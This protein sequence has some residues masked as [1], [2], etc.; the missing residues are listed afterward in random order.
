MAGGFA[1]RPQLT[2]LSPRPKSM[3]VAQ[4]SKCSTSSTLFVLAFEPDGL[5]SLLAPRDVDPPGTATHGAV[6]L[7]ALLFGSAWVDINFC[8]FAAVRAPKLGL[9]V[10]VEVELSHH[11]AGA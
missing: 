2:S 8:R 10:Q 1:P 3:T 9:R 6:L 4:S 11:R 7:E 5:F